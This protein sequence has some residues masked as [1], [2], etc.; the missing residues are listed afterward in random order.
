[1]AVI[2]RLVIL[3][4]GDNKDA[5]DAGWT[6]DWGVQWD[7][8]Y[9]C[10]AIP[11]DA[12]DQAPLTGPADIRRNGVYFVKVPQTTEQSIKNGRPPS[13][14][15]AKPLKVQSGDRLVVY[16]E[17]TTMD[18]MT[19]IHGRFVVAPNATLTAVNIVLDPRPFV[20]GETPSKAPDGAY[21]PALT[22][23]PQ[24]SVT[25]KNCGV[26]SAP[27]IQLPSGAFSMKQTIL[28]GANPVDWD[29]RDLNFIY[30]SLTDITQGQKM[31][32]IF[33][34]VSLVDPKTQKCRAESPD[35]TL[36]ISNGQKV[37]LRGPKP[38]IAAA[39]LRIGLKAF[40]NV[41][42][43]GELSIRYL[44]LTAPSKAHH[45]PG[46]IQID[47]KAMLTIANT[48]LADKSTKNCRV[49]DS[50]LPRS[51]WSWI[52]QDLVDRNVGFKSR[53][54]SPSDSTLKLAGPLSIFTNT[55]VLRLF[56]ATQNKFSSTLQIN[57][58][59]NTLHAVKTAGATSPDTNILD[60][61]QVQKYPEFSD[62][63]LLSTSFQLGPWRSAVYI[64]KDE[65]IENVPS[66]LEYKFRGSYYVLQFAQEAPS[67]IVF[68]NT[69][70]GELSMHVLNGQDLRL[71]TTTHRTVIHIS[72]TALKVAP[73]GSV[74]TSLVAFPS[75]SVGPKKFSVR[76]QLETDACL[77]S[78]LSGGNTYI[79]GVT[80]KGS[81]VCRDLNQFQGTARC[82]HGVCWSD[83]STA[84]GNHVIEVA[85]NEQCDLGSKALFPKA[86][87]YNSKAPNAVCREDCTFSKCGDAIVVKGEECDVGDIAHLCKL[88]PVPDDP[89]Y[90]TCAEEWLA[91]S[92]CEDSLGSETCKQQKAKGCCEDNSG[93]CVGMALQCRK[94]CAGSRQELCRA[95]NSNRTDSCRADCKKP[96]CGDGITDSHEQCDPGCVPGS[97]SAQIS[98]A[99]WAH[100][101]AVTERG[102]CPVCSDKCS[103]CQQNHAD[104]SDLQTYLLTSHG[105]ERRMVNGSLTGPTWYNMSICKGKAGSTNITIQPSQKVKI[106]YAKPGTG[107]LEYSMRYTVLGQ[108]V[109]SKL[110]VSKQHYSGTDFGGA[111]IVRSQVP[112]RSLTIK[113]CTIEEN[114]VSSNGGALA[115]TKG[116]VEVVDSGFSNNQADGDGG[117]I[118]VSASGSARLKNVVFSGN[119]ATG[120]GGAIW[121]AP[122]TIKF[123]KA[124]DHL[125]VIAC[126]FKLNTATYGGAV[127]PGTGARL[128]NDDGSGGDKPVGTHFL[129]PKK[130]HASGKK[131]PASGTKK[132]ASGKKKPASGKTKPA[133]GTKKPEESGKKKPKESGKE[134]PKESGKKKHASGT[135]KHSSGKKGGKSG[136]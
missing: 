9:K 131:K 106:G 22:V 10:L 17:A 44:R 27:A 97:P 110:H 42:A 49:S 57:G 87:V 73:G 41:A 124:G 76:G 94:T 4:H 119:K 108:L 43:G 13:L 123:A 58:T 33:Q 133:S 136:H 48:Q 16:G 113:G 23:A 3:P 53:G 1:M 51:C 85:Q 24:A 39:D 112:R 81:I 104:F 84:C 40:I 64:G 95:L 67:D 107:E 7:L 26:S 116:N 109:L 103:L 47:S 99:A 88:H 35:C 59:D 2:K 90:A 121:A 62:K 71:V 120:N 11:P 129:V 20:G 132:P 118:W 18:T 80:D 61:Q 56:S 117:A 70:R 65:N 29:S 45:H 63:I 15:F 122:S 68:R 127:Y 74:Y 128:A 111:I 50:K 96:A 32:Q 21:W 115:V 92:I 37:D 105:G 114:A 77:M 66:L 14:R 60:E 30:Q 34:D 55:S 93:A 125:S 91:P 25:I 135:K 101:G 46:I 75:L 126:T 98:W 5:N 83:P 6:L 89:R 100:L 38:S 69:A 52:V 12:R 86:K 130:T 19:T 36:H 102:Q 72:G 78:I 31:L 134:K 82:N 28:S 8:A 79:E 54:T